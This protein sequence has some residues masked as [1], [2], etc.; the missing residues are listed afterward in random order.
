MRLTVEWDNPEHFLLQQ[1][2]IEV[3]PLAS[4][5]APAW[6]DPSSG[7]AVLS[8][9]G[10]PGH[11]EFDAAGTSYIRFHATFAWTPPRVIGALPTTILK[12][13]QL[14]AVMNGTILPSRWSATGMGQGGQAIDGLHPLLAVSATS[15]GQAGP[16]VHMSTV[17]VD[18]TAHWWN[19]RGESPYVTE[20]YRNLHR[21][22]TALRVLAYT[23]A[24]PL[25]WFDPHVSSR[26]RPGGAGW[27]RAS[28][29]EGTPSRSRRPDRVGVPGLRHRGPRFPRGPQARARGARPRHPPR[30]RRP[31]CT[32][33][34]GANP[35]G[36]RSLAQGRVFPLGREGPRRRSWPATISGRHHAR[37][38]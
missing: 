27:R 34:G 16:T 30:A 17:F 32:S 22:G 31:R 6:L 28:A 8:S 10:R 14:F 3:A 36:G 37:A 5:E 38:R 15:V 33:S 26:I 11:Q 21:P 7:L 19:L 29:L 12:I 24:L 9:N 20:W 23:S 25:L 35:R 1:H 2:A 13:T 4:T 18:V